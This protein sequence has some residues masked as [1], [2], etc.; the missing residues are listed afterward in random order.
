MLGR[1][2]SQ[3]GTDETKSDGAETAEVPSPSQTGA[4]G[5]DQRGDHQQDKQR[6][7]RHGN[8]LQKNTLPARDSEER[9]SQQELSE[10][11]GMKGIPLP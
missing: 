3:K 6:E 8:I 10:L 2:G 9:C 7:K 11:P 1:K 4:D 5:S